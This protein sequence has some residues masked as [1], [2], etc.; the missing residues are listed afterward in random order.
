MLWFCSDN[1][2]EGQKSEIA[3]TDK[4][5]RPSNAGAPGS[6]GIFR[7]RK[8]DLFEGGIRVPAFLYWP[9]GLN[10]GRRTDFPAV[11]S[12]YLPT[13]LHY[14][15]IDYPDARPLDG[16]NLAGTIGNETEERPAPI[17]FHF[18]NKQAI[19]T[20]R[21]KL[22]TVDGGQSWMLFDLAADAAESNNIAEDH[23][24]TVDSLK[25]QLVQWIAGCDRSRAG[26]DYS[27]GPR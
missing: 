4:G 20:N 24:E 27:K 12:D 13:I 1:G 9:Q 16:M 18:R 6:A 25:A 15:D 26:M 3:Y 14:L 22:I 10:G 23:K 8:R 17:L 7:G 2:P 11:T 19:T 5:A 21:E